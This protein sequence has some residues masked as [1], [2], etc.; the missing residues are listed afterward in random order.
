MLFSNKYQNL[1]ISLFFFCILLIGFNTYTDYSY[2][3]DDEY[4]RSNGIFFLE[5][6]KNLFN[7]K[8]LDISNIHIYKQINMSASPVF[9]DLLTAF[10]VDIFNIENQKRISETANILNFSFFFI[11]LILFYKI[12]KNRYENKIYGII[13]VLAIFLTP[14]IFAESFYNSRDI[15]FMSVFIFNIFFMQNFFNKPTRTNAIIFSISSGLCF[16]TKILYLIPYTIM[17]FF[18]FMN[19]LN[20][21]KPFK[22]LF[23]IFLILSFTFI[24]LIIFWPFLIESP[25]ENLIYAYQYNL[26]VQQNL[27]IM[28]LFQG[29]YI[30]SLNSPWFYRPVWF[31]ITTPIFI[32]IFLFIG[33]WFLTIRIINRLFNLDKNKTDIWRGNKEL[34]DL[35]IFLIFLI[36][37]YITC[38]FNLSQYGS[39]R[40]LYYLYPLIILISLNSIKFLELFSKKKNVKYFCFIII[41][42]NFMYLSLW[43]FKNHPYQFVY[44][45]L[46]SKSYAKNNFDLDYWGQSNLNALNYVIKNH[47]T[48]P[49]KIGSLSFVTLEA[50]YSML[51]LEDKEKVIITYNLENADILF[52]NNIKKIRNQN[53]DFLKNYEVF[54]KITIDDNVINT[55]YKK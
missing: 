35:L 9:F 15:F 52:D 22:N 4:Y 6:L 13:G 27:N 41:I 3:V 14:R 12:L 37:L 38:R 5:Y 23:Y 51:K 28:N 30:N 10:V 2:T 54:Y 16:A 1:F 19:F 48:Y 55:V 40:H 50:A 20:K 43:S 26:S 33:I 34:F 49:L 7:T 36:S 11:S 47:D 8:D 31:L 29:E 21:I 17:I 53:L 44:F 32:I 46:F 24:F 45:N 42:S 18:I 25:L 39:W